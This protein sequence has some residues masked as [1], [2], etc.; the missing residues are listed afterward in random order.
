MS[1]KW[2][3]SIQPLTQSL[4]LQ[5]EHKWRPKGKKN[6][7]QLNKRKTHITDSVSSPTS[8]TPQSSLR[9]AGESLSL[10]HLHAD[11]VWNP[12][13]LKSGR[14][15]QYSL[16]LI[17]WKHI[18]PLWG[19]RKEWEWLPLVDYSI[20]DLCGWL[21]NL[22]VTWWTLNCCKG[23]P[24]NVFS[25]LL[26]AM[27]SPFIWPQSKR[28]LTVFSKTKCQPRHDNPSLS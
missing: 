3:Y 18:F 19:S 26:P 23:H 13:R 22:S 6:K 10:G 2:K 27:S 8:V 9:R 1:E 11:L 14:H 12:L 5:V 17:L 7:C 21:H 4:H 25:L 24:T 15:H 28:L 16:E 20:N